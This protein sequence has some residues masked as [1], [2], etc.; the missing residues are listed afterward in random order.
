MSAAGHRCHAG[1][2]MIAQD[3][4]VREAWLV[5]FTFADATFRNAV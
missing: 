4:Q 5:G 3:W 2:G 1:A